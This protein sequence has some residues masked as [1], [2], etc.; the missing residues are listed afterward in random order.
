MDIYLDPCTSFLSHCRKI[1]SRLLQVHSPLCYSITNSY[2]NMVCNQQQHHL[3]L[4][5]L[6]HIWLRI[7]I[8]T[9]SP[10]DSYVQW[11]LRI[12]DLQYTIKSKQADKKICTYIAGWH[13]SRGIIFLKC[14]RLMHNV[15]NMN[16]VPFWYMKHT[17]CSTYWLC[18][19]W[20]VIQSL[21]ASFSVL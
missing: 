7:W 20:L 2:L 6:Q 3:E 1:V 12:S 17:N 16:R 4:Q 5:N 15:R 9:R 13:A 21:W 18:D 10:R 14:T 11:I 19:I 8:L